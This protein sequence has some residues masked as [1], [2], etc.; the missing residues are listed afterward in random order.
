MDAPTGQHPTQRLKSI[1]LNQKCPS[2]LH[3]LVYYV[4]KSMYGSPVCHLKVKPNSHQTTNPTD[5]LR[6]QTTRKLLG[7][8]WK[9][10]WCE[11]PPTAANFLSKNRPISHRFRPLICERQLS[12]MFDNIGGIQRFFC[13]FLLESPLSYDI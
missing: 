3:Q 7:N 4:L 11:H 8:L 13:I 10:V 12:S 5:F 6:L 1:G 9:I 2:L